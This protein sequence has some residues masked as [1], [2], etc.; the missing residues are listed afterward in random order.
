MGRTAT[1]IEKAKGPRPLG[2]RMTYEEFLDWLED[3]VHAEWVDGEVV[4]MAPVGR[5]HVRL[6]L[7]LL[8]LLGE[9]LEQRPLGELTFDPFNM[10][11][12]D[13]L[14]GRA[15]DILFV[16][17]K[18]LRRLK[19]SHLKGP[20]DLVV[21]IVSPGS[22]GVDRGHKFYEY[23]TGG[24]GEYWILDP[25]RKQAE[26]YQRGSSGNFQ[27]VLPDEHGVFRSRAMKGLWVSV[28]WFWRSPFPTLRSIRKQ[29]KLDNA[30]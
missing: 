11:T 6:H 1:V 20:A 10:K 9:Y 2:L 17:N 4:M 5:Q 18:N 23:E 21:E 14:P 3:G 22:A 12:G 28:R 13:G 24:V 30:E 25:Y 16:A 19:D 15:P 8:R 7:F 29:W 26:F 27:V